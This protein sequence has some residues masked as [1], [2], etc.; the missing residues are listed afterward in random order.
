M[1]DGE[2]LSWSREHFV[3]V[4]AIFVDLERWG[5]F[6]LLIKSAIDHA[7]SGYI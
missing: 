3:P 7:N 6:V 1:Y 2:N 4:R 5:L